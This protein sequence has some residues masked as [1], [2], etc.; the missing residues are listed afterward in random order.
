MKEITEKL[1]LNKILKSHKWFIQACC[2]TSGDG[3]FEGLDWLSN[4]ILN[5]EVKKLTSESNSIG[6]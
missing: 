6:I 5:A 4:V 3:I 1:E 2:A